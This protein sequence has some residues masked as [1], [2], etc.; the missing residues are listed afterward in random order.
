MKIIYSSDHKLHDPE[1]EKA[2]E[3]RVAHVERPERLITIVRALKEK[4]IGRL[5]SPTRFPF[6]ALYKVHSKEYVAFLRKTCASLGEKDLVYP[7]THSFDT[8]TPLRKG[9]YKAAKVA[10]D[11]ALTGAEFLLNGE[12]VVYSLCRPP[13]HHA[14]W[15]M[16]GGYCYFNN[17][18]VVADY[19][20][21]FGDVAILDIDFHHGN[22][23]Q[24]IFYRRKDVLYV[25]IHA[26]PKVRFPYTTGFSSE[27]GSGEGAGFTKNYPLPL[28]IGDTQY[29]DVLVRAL[30]D[31]TVFQPSYLIVSAGFDT[32][33]NDPIGG[34]TLTIPFYE[35]IARDI[36]A[37]RIPTLI[38]QEGGY[39]VNDLGKIAVSFSK[40]LMIK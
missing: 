22:G 29:R 9:T 6:P 36:T 30:K 11:C 5:V 16:M 20:S 13:G 26:D 15:D 12:S 10:V 23:T 33:Q 37:L 21:T 27:S 31:V 17:A 40:G 38:V 24:D 25:S 32:F 14:S 39:A 2:H 18:A 28:G 7:Y 1:W 34:F 35:T 19:L 4:N 8:Y 3:K